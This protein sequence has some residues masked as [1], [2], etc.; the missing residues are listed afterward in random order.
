MFLQPSRNPVPKCIPGSLPSRNPAPKWVPGLLRIFTGFG[1][2]FRIV[3]RKQPAATR[4]WKKHRIFTGFGRFFRNCYPQTTR[5]N[6]PPVS[7][8][9]T[10]CPSSP[11]THSRKVLNK[12][13]CWC[14]LIHRTPPPLHSDRRRSKAVQMSIGLV[15][16]HGDDHG[17]ESIPICE[18]TCAK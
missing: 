17:N 18:Y 5:C 4:R 13:M 6:P 7:S 3:T 9:S 16:L 8:H 14:E 11:G 12:K 2:F 1:R 10:M 15:S